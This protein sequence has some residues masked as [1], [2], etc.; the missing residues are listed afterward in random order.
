MGVLIEVVVVVVVIIA[1][2]R[3]V[4]TTTS[5]TVA[6]PSLRDGEAATTAPTTGQEVEAA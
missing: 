6:T 4:R 1:V 5:I 3:L 2:A